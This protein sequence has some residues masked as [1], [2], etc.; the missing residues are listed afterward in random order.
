MNELTSHD[1]KKIF[2]SIQNSKIKHRNLYEIIMVEILINDFPYI[3]LHITLHFDPQE[4]LHRWLHETLFHFAPFS[5]FVLRL[6]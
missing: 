3:P 6:M 5:V 2:Y 4:N 1:S